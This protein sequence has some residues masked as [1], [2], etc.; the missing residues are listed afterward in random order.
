MDSKAGDADVEY[1]RAFAFRN[2]V[3]EWKWKSGMRI[4]MAL[5]MLRDTRAARA[6]VKDIARPIIEPDSLRDNQRQDWTIAQTNRIKHDSW[7][8]MSVA[9]KE[10]M[11]DALGAVRDRTVEG[12]ARLQLALALAFNFTPGSLDTLFAVVHDRAGSELPIGH[13]A[14]PPPA[15]ESD[16]VIRFLQVLAYAV[17]HSGLQRFQDLFVDGFDENFSDVDRCEDIQEKLKQPD[18]GVLLTVPRACRADLKCYL[19][20]LKGGAGAAKGSSIKYD[21]AAFPGID[22]EETE[23]LKSMGRTKAALVLGRWDASARKRAVIVKTLVEVYSSLPYNEELYGDLRLSILLGLERMG[24]R[25]PAKVADALEGMISKE[26][27]KGASAEI[28]NQRLEALR[29]FLGH[30]N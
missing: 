11:V 23:Y 1:L 29:L 6:L 10:I 20:V 4:P 24:R 12:S 2:A 21:P 14:L 22:E 7:A 30:L 27:G 18:I 26:A 19:K 16:F 3:S 25:S 17:D 15:K 28:W 9:H 5:A 13:A 8:L